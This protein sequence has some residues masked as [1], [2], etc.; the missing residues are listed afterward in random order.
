MNPSED[1]TTDLGE[2]PHEDPSR[3]K[4]A[5]TYRQALYGRTAKQ[6]GMSEQRGG[7]A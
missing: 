7:D 1:D 6:F 2:V 4:D 5:D 3:A